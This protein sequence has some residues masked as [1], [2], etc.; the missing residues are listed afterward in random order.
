MDENFSKT[1][2]IKKFKKQKRMKM[3]NERMGGWHM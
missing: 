2:K 1:N 3:K